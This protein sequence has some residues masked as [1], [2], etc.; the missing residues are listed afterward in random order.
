MQEE[1]KYDLDYVYFDNRIFYSIGKEVWCYDVEQEEK[2]LLLTEDMLSS[3]WQKYPEETI[4]NIYV[5]STKLYIKA[6]TPDIVKRFSCPWRSAGKKECKWEKGLDM[7]LR[8]YGGLDVE[9][10]TIR[11]LSGVW[12]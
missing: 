4:W 1:K 2:L 12:I 3:F 11:G 8:E 10:E 5:D 9:V 6:Y 7:C